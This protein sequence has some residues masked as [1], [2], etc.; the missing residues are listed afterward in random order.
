MLHLPWKFTDVKDI[1][2]VIN[3]DFPGTLEDYVHRIGRTGRAGAK[4]LAFSFFTPSNARSARE[5]VKILREAGQAV[6][7]ALLSMIHSTPGISIYCP[8]Q[9]EREL[10]LE[11]E[12][13][14]EGE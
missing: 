6:S 5:L 4:G 11:R 13:E 3:Y 1:K 7:P 8:L 10:R 9:V 12:R 2:C 14:F